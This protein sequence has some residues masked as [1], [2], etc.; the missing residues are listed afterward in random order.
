M[1]DVGVWRY[2]LGD[3]DAVR[4]HARGLT[5]LSELDEDSL[6]LNCCCSC[7][8]LGIMLCRLALVLRLVAMSMIA[9]GVPIYWCAVHSAARLRWRAPMRP[10][11]AWSTRDASCRCSSERTR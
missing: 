11:S 8:K 6:V 10:R 3:E 9:N 7:S 2:A 4:L 5:F 1:R